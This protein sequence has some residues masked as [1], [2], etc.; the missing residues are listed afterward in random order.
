MKLLVVHDNLN[1]YELRKHRPLVDL[2]KSTSFIRLGDA[3]LKEVIGATKPNVVVGL[4]EQCLR[5]LT[6][7]EQIHKWR[8]S[9][10]PSTLVDGLKVICTLAPE[11][12]SHRMNYSL[13]RLVSIDL[14]RA[15]RQSGF[16]EI[17]PESSEMIIAPTY[18][19][20]TQFLNTCISQ[21][22]AGAVIDYD[23]ETL[24]HKNKATGR[25]EHQLASVSFAYDD[26]HVICIPLIG[27]DGES[28]FTEDDEYRLM[29]MMNELF[30][31]PNIV[32]RG[33]NVIFDSH[34]MLKHYGIRTYNLLDTMIAQIMIWPEMRKGLD[35]I[36]SVW[37]DMPYYKDEGKAFKGGDGDLVD[38]WRYNCLDALATAR[39]HPKQV[40]AL[41]SQGNYE[42]YL[43]RCSLIEPLTYMTERGIR[44]D[45][46]AM[47]TADE[48][49]KARISELVEAVKAEVGYDI[50]TN[51]TQQLQKYF[52]DEQS[53]DPIISRKTG[54]P[55]VDKKALEKIASLGH[56]VAQDILEARKL[57]K[58]SSTFLN[59]ENVSIDGRMRS[60][61]DPAGTKFGRLSSSH[62]KITGEGV[63]MQNQ[64]HEAL[65]YY[66]A[67]DGYIVY[68]LD[69]SQI[70][71]RI[72]AYV[73]GIEKMI[74]AF[75]TGVD[76]HKLTAAETLS[77]IDKPTSVDDITD[78]QRQDYG[79]KP[80]HAFN[81]GFGAA[82]YAYLHEIDFEL[83]KA[84]RDG[85][86]A[87]YPELRTGYW[88]YVRQ[89][90]FEKRALT[91]LT[92]RTISFLGDLQDY[93]TI[94]EAYSAIPQGT[95]ADV[96]NLRGVAFIYYN[97]EPHFETVELLT[98]VHDSV[99]F[100]MP[101]TTSLV[102]HA[103]VL[104]DV[105]QSLQTPLEFHG[106]SFSVPADLTIG[107]CLNKGHRDSI[108]L[109][110]SEFPDGWIDIHNTLSL[111][112]AD[113]Q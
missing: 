23:I 21:G 93:D 69:M 87:A 89:C 47:L 65:S 66:L 104:A 70:E 101:L 52:Y 109:K 20:A 11:D 39:A 84:I 50:N 102:D 27:E 96:T 18:E 64:P 54:R 32:K 95:C 100:Q 63:N 40:A 53:I 103:K 12:W 13:R 44:I 41:R 80:N 33:Q 37:T 38:G 112:R 105:K 108:E 56:P 59:T 15:V 7:K 17:A 25:L 68:A 110:G 83:A 88:K 74:N 106:R 35:F 86:H 29:V 16:A 98:Q 57:S 10:L 58:M 72:V 26:M 76:L 55:T 42:S 6:G 19:Q 91:T 94:K 111:L 43:Q 82:S 3:R 24:S 4:G 31:N 75:E 78:Q 45:T 51:S 60:S 92:G 67:D 113:Y 30:T 34:F 5:S 14:D 85:Y 28:Y 46:D 61:Y 77:I 99:V 79:K 9:I 36:T 71:N 90:L 62:S 22:K 81:Y 73:G 1:K 97:D 49:N 107:T 8:G 48:N 2:P